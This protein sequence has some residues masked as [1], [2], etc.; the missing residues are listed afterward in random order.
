MAEAVDG[1]GDVSGRGAGVVGAAGAAEPAGVVGVGVGVGATAIGALAV[2]ATGVCRS[3]VTAAHAR[4]PSSLRALTAAL[5]AP[6]EVPE[7]PGLADCAPAGAAVN[8][9]KN[10]NGNESRTAKESFMG[11]RGRAG[12]WE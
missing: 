4:S 3:A 12:C 1:L 5:A 7:F 2:A 6:G 11:R 8:N 9:T 10:K